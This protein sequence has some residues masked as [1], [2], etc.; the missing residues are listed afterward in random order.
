[1]FAY[2]D[3]FQTKLHY[4]VYSS[5]FE[6]YQQEQQIAFVFIVFESMNSNELCY[7]LYLQLHKLKL[8]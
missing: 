2:L 1:M 4:S 3:S 7:T 8:S 5:E 6:F